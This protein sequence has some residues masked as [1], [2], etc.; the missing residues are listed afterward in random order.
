MEE[1][2]N[3]PEERLNSSEKQGNTANSRNSDCSNDNETGRKIKEEALD[4]FQTP[5]QIPEQVH[6]NPVDTTPS[7]RNLQHIERMEEAFEDGYDTDKEIGPFWGAT[8]IEGEQDPEERPLESINGAGNADGNM[9]TVGESSG[10]SAEESAHG[11]ADRKKTIGITIDEILSKKAKWI[12]LELRLRLLSTTGSKRIK[13]NRL[14][15]RWGIRRFD[16]I[17][18]AN[19]AKAK[20]PKKKKVIDTLK[21]FPGTAKWLQL[22]PNS[23]AVQ[24]PA[25]PTFRQPRAP[26]IKAEHAAFVP[27]KYEFD[28][29]F[30]V[31]LFMGTTERTVRDQRGKI[32][33][34]AMT[35]RPQK[36]IEPRMKGQV[37]EAFKK[38]HKLSSNSKPWEFVDAFFPF[39]EDKSTDGKDHFSFEKITRW[40]NHKAILAG[41]GETTYKDFKPFTTREIR[42]HFG[43]YVLHGIQ[44]SMRVEYKFRSQRQDPVSGNDFVNRSFGA[45]AERRHKHFKA[46]LACVD[47]SILT[48]NR[49]KYPNWKVRALIKWINKISPEA[50][51]CAMQIAVDEMTMR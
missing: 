41:A 46:F 34:D 29:T 11:S 7:E 14:H 1:T 22:L 49:D 27:K 8:H 13:A 25:N 44:P 21:T 26:T 37:N 48:P 47:P 10:G 36:T 9:P 23:V 3:I 31:P 12:E 20:L 45:N 42:Q 35:G 18:E 32:K 28:E 24:E 50:W 6:M 17:E 16:T 33:L 43:I 38:K 19:A 15:E 2:N 51:S 5:K 39:H 40:T 30:E 4:T